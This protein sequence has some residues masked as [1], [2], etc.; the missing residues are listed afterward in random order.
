MNQE[1]EN[2]RKAEG[3]NDNRD[4]SSLRNIWRPARTLWKKPNNFK[5]KLKVS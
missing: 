1:E 3:N 4:M 5:L 2:I